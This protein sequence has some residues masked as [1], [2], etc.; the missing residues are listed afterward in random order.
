MDREAALRAL[1]LSPRAQPDEIEA[2][3]R[4]RADALKREVLTATQPE[5]IARH[6]EELRTLVRRRDAALGSERAPSPDELGISVRQLVTMLGETKVL[7]LDRDGARRFLGL[8][9][10]VSDAEVDLAYELRKRALIRR[11]ARVKAPGEVSA[12]R[13]AQGKLRTIRNFA[14]D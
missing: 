13:R 2:A 3:Y 6:R 5:V 11:Y 12:I 1:G 4:K 8:E 10:T 9:P 14:L 7:D